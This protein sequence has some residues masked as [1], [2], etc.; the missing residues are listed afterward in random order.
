MKTCTQCGESKE[1]EAFA[2]N[3]TQKDGRNPY[4]KICRR[5]YYIRTQEIRRWYGR[6]YHAENKEARKVYMEVWRTKNAERIKQYT[7][8]KS[9]IRKR[10]R[11]EHPEMMRASR[12]KW[13]QNNRW[14][15]RGQEERRRARLHETESDFRNGDWED[16][17]FAYDYRCAYC[18][19]TDKPLTKDHV[20]PLS[21]GG[22]HTVNNI[23]PACHS[24]NCKKHARSREEF[25][26]ANS[27]S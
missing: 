20:E 1:L 23:I 12:K 21:R 15:L 19:R 13:K 18:G 27:P 9:E 11:C 7:A 22:T 17:L 8:S 3:R 16:I 25:L 4:C 5:A 24:C 10:Y 6:K 2:I 14:S 26:N